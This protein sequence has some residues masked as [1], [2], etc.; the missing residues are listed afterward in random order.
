ME[1]IY[2]FS[3]VGRNTSPKLTCRF[4]LRLTCDLRIIKRVPEWVGVILVSMESCREFDALAPTRPT[5]I[6][7]LKVS[8]KIHSSAR[9]SKS[10]AN[11]S[12]LHRTWVDFARVVLAPERWRNPR[13]FP[14]R[15]P[16]RIS[17]RGEIRVRQIA[18]VRSEGFL[19]RDLCTGMHC[20]S[21]RVG[22]IF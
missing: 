7:S 12:V 18:R 15:V 11:W 13:N 14:K 4:P 17:R 1:N 3:S 6:T 22:I 5:L 21:K 10:R 16:W 2:V 8:R 9:W 20:K 19:Y